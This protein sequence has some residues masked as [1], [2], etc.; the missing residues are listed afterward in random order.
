MRKRVAYSKNENKLFYCKNKLNC[1]K[2]LTLNFLNL[3]AD[4]VYPVKKIHMKATIG[5]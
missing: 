5:L 1:A 4:M 3:Y 2:N